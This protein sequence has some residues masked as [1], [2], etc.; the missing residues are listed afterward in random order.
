MLRKSLAAASALLLAGQFGCYNTF[1]VS[2][3]ELGKA[4]EGG[5]SAVVTITPDDC[6]TDECKVQIT[7]D[8]KIGVTDKGGVYHPVSPFNFTL[9][10]NQLVAPD[11]DLL[12]N[13]GEIETGN[14]KVVSGTRTTLLVTSGFA[15][16]LGAALYVVFTAPEP[17][18]FGQ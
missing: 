4:Q 17:R 7:E 12:L 8:A 1:N 11:E 5:R 16:V 9:T 2:L 14:V 18:E 15:A 13:R 6:A 10:R 3:D